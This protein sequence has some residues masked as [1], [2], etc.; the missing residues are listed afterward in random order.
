[1]KNG[2]RPTKNQKIAMKNAGLNADN[3]L[4]SKNITDE[5]HL[6]HRNTGNKRVILL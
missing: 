4:V 2:K 1:M 6:V 3:W 5:L